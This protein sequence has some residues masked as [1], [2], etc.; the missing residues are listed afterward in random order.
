MKRLGF[1]FW[2]AAGLV[3]GAAEAAGK[4][5]R[6]EITNA[7]IARLFANLTVRLAK[8]TNSIALTYELARLESM[9][10]ATDLTELPVSKRSGYIRFESP[11]SD[12]LV[13]ASTPAFA[14]PEARAAGLRHLTNAIHFYERAIVLLKQPNAREGSWM[15]TPV[16][17]GLAWCLDQAG[18][19][20][21]AIEAYWNALR[22]VW[23]AE[24]GNQDLQRMLKEPWNR[25]KDGPGL[26][27][28]NGRGARGPGVCYSQEIVDYLRK[29]LDPVKDA[30]D[31][32]LLAEAQASINQWWRAVTPILVAWEPAADFTQLVAP[33]ARVRFDLDGS[34]LLREWG[35]I[36]PKAA[37]LVYD[38]SHRGS[39]KSGLQMFGNVTFWIFWANGYQALS[40]LDDNGDGVLT[41]A[42]LSGL[43]LW[44]DRN[45]N[46]ISEP[47]EVIPVGS[48][49]ITAIGCSCRTNAAGLPWNPV[50]VI[51][52]NGTARATYDWMVPGNSVRT[53]GSGRE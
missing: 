40:A 6:E 32:A 9:A 52:T 14:T 28:S 43:A 3:L 10:Y 23:A 8:D 17:L 46:G 39:I 42:E 21:A 49:G 50:G 13:P 27:A 1:C 15:A 53:V 48:L 51:L 37:W 34:G 33:D 4:F 45:G 22:M 35:W 29:L 30:A 18:R 20:S 12:H 36:T 38:P 16:H 47:G 44:F 11:Y 31:V 24:T 25:A 19:R 7:P 5:A 41:G 26:F 2:I